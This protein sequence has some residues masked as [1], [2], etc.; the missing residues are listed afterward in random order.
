MEECD[1]NQE[2]DVAPALIAFH[3]NHKSVSVAVGSDLRVFDLEN[4][5]SVKLVDDSANPFHKGS[6]R[7]IRYGAS[8]KLFVSAGDDKL[9]KIWDSETWRCICTISSGKR[10]TAVALTHDCSFVCFADKFGVVWAVNLDEHLKS[11]D[12]EIKKA[13]PIL[14]HYCSIITRLEFSPDGRF[15]ISA[16]RDFKI[17]VTLFPKFPSDG[18]NEIQSFCLG[19]TQYV[20]CLSFICTSQHPDGFLVSGSGDSTVRVWDII[21][22]SLLATCDVG[23]EAGLIESDKSEE[24]CTLAVTDICAVPDHSL[25]AV[26]IQSLSGIMLLNYNVSVR[27]LSLVK[28]ISIPEENFVPTSLGIGSKDVLWMVS[29]ISNLQGV[30]SSCLARVRVISGLNKTNPDSIE[31]GPVLLDDNDVPGSVELLEKLQGNL[32]IKKEML[33]EASEILKY[34]MRKLLIKKH[35]S[36]ENRD[37]RKRERNDRKNKR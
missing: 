21:T 18:A 16:D 9:I 28:V 12:V 37:F 6:I 2:M 10:I 8:G 32:A 5:C 13:A 22:G 35:Y 25:V 29:G 34:A 27:S 20:S 14:S 17:R 7:A 36:V 31:S 24:E 33:L 19:H 1:M 30:A 4:G 11:Q 23:V 15:I 3:S 26:A